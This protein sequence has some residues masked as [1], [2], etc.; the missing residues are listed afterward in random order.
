M[1]N[2]DTHI[3]QVRGAYTDARG[4]AMGASTVRLRFRLRRLAQHSNDDRQAAA[5]KA[6]RD[7]LRDRG[8]AEVS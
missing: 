6:L 5:A 1:S 7:E 8:H 2:R 3:D 4:W